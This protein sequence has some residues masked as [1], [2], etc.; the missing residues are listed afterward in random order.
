MLHLLFDGQFNVTFVFPEKKESPK[1][2]MEQITY[3]PQKVFII[4]II[5][6]IFVVEAPGG[7]PRFFNHSLYIGRSA[8][9]LI[10]QY[11]VLG[12]FPF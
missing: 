1:N 4:E 6:E 10:I 3:L 9:D 2:K 11:L 12:Q 7:I 5:I 8:N